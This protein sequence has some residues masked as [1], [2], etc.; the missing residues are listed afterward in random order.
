MEWS[1]TNE[2]DMV[3]FDDAVP[4]LN[5]S[6]ISACLVFLIVT[7]AASRLGVLFVP[8]GLSHDHSSLPLIHGPHDCDARLALVAVVWLAALGVVVVAV[9]LLRAIV[10]FATRRPAGG[11]KSH[12]ALRVLAAAVLMVVPYVPYSHVRAASGT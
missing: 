6:F 5:A 1:P 4:D 2:T 7:I 11:L 12:R 3:A 9:R 10:C 8:L